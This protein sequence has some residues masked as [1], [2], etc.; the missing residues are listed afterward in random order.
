[1]FQQTPLFVVPEGLETRWATP[2][3]FAG[4]KGKGAQAK[5]GRKGAAYFQLK[6]GQRQV[7]SGVK[8]ASG[9]VRRIWFTIQERGVQTLRGIRFDIYWDGCKKPAVSAP[10]GDFFMM[11]LGRT[12]VFE[13]A[14]F[15][16]PEGR[17]FNCYAPMPF[18]KGM[19]MVLTNESDLLQTIYSEVDY[20]LGDRHG[21]D[22]LYF[23]AHYRR[24]NPTKLRKDYEILP[25]VAGLGRYLGTNIGVIVNKKLY[26]NTWWGEGEVKI[27]MDGDRKFPTL[28]N[29]GTEDYAGSGHGQATF[30]QL[31]HG[32]PL[33]KDGHVC[34]YRLHIPD[35]V[36]FRKDVRVTIQVMGSWAS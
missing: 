21:D 10:I 20:T 13:S 2:E 33:N 32:S 34:F 35:P 23:H 4:E 28:C 30:S 9:M 8:G 3:N 36:Y 6:P 18:R 19:K 15:C 25:R 5:Y 24:E 14:L 17:S 22:A 16:S 1:M 31:Y 12:T 26:L 11:G 7:I 29:T 27:Y